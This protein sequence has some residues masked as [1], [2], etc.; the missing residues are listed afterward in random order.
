MYFVDAHQAR[1]TETSDVYVRALEG[2]SDLFQ[3]V[4][5][6]AVKI[7]TITIESVFHV[8]LYRVHLRFLLL[9]KQSY[10]VKVRAFQLFVHQMNYICA[11][12]HKCH[13]R[14]EAPKITQ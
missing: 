3:E 11:N 10:F 9:T 7:C 1:T 2:Y 4:A 14:V 5:V 6:T 13:V 8:L 12:A